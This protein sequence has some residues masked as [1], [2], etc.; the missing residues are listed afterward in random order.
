MPQS[1]TA[2]TTSTDSTTTPK[3]G[4]KIPRQL[5]SSADD[6]R[7]KPIPGIKAGW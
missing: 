7:A 6:D 1:T 5:G 3:T 4:V 2:R